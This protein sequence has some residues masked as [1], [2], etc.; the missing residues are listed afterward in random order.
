MHNQVLFC[1]KQAG[2]GLSELEARCTELSEDMGIDLTDV[3][4]LITE[5]P[6]KQ[7]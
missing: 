4:D 7:M 3:P 1:L 2:M 5:L 6:K